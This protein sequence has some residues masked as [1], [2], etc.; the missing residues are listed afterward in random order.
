MFSLYVF[1]SE[2]SCKVILFNLEALYHFGLSLEIMKPS[3]H[4][5]EGIVF[6]AGCVLL[7]NIELMRSLIDASF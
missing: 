5:K 6:A 3:P 4:L 7:G 1:T 2:I